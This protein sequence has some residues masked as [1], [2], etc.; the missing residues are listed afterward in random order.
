MKITMLFNKLKTGKYDSSDPILIDEMFEKGKGNA[1]AYYRLKNRLKNDLEKSLLNLHNDLDERISTINLLALASIFSYKSQYDL[2]V[3]NL[4]KAEKIA[5]ENEFYDLLDTIYGDLIQLSDNLHEVNPIEYINRR[6][7]N[8]EKNKI[9][10]EAQHAISAIN[11]RLKRSNF[12]A[13]ASEVDNQLHDI[14]KELQIAN[15]VFKMPKVKF[16]IHFC[17][18]DTLLQ[19]KDFFGL[20]HY[21]INTLNEFETENLFTKSTHRYKITLITWIINTLTI[22]RKWDESIKYT[23]LLNVELQKFGGLLYDNFIWTYNQ[24]LITNYMSSGRVRNA[25]ELLEKLKEQP[26][27]KGVTF[28]DYAIHVNLSLC[29]YF[30][31]NLTAAIKTLANLFH[32]DIYPKLSI[33]FQFSISLL[34][35]LFHYENNNNDFA[36]YRLGEIKRL[37]VTLLRRDE[38]QDEKAFLKIIQSLL[39]KAEP[40]ENKHVLI[41]IESFIK[42]APGIQVGSSKHIDY[43]VWLKSKTG[44]TKYYNDL[45]ESL[46]V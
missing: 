33:E 20:E 26:T 23:E 44:K 38:Y 28:Y 4:K 10:I 9:H 16:K 3:N 17:I 19:K 18:R 13:N 21:L 12:G 41:A 6:K 42:T 22:N 37:F 27:H 25:I 40:F 11:Y 45:V 24:S 29:Y 5:S 8:A 15:E 46:K 7:E 30:V 32:K 31:D 35:V 39:N 34:E 43:A 2:A 36:T 14:V 1:N